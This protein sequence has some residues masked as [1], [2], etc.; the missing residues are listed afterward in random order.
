M[1]PAGSG[2]LGC[3]CLFALTLSA[4]CESADPQ[5]VSVEGTVVTP[6]QKPLSAAVITLEPMPDTPGP[7][8]STGIFD[9]RFEFSPEAGLRGGQYRV[10]ISLLPP[11]MRRSLPPDVAAKAPPADAVIAPKYDGES[12][13][14]CELEPG[15]PNSL[16]FTVDFL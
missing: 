10:R 14:S 9:G 15:Q 8:A 3:V 6:D 12:E 11:E 5:G 1:H 7:N 16:T 4:G 2:F 13:I